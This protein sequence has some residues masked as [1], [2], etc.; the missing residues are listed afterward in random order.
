MT[1]MA[2]A[3][4]VGVDINIDELG[5]DVLASLFNEELGAVLQVRCEDTDS[6][7]TRFADA[8]VSISKLGWLN[9]D[10]VALNTT[11]P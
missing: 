4:H 1:E 3:G 8:G 5:D 11:V 6:V 9:T 10:T 2:F 7:I